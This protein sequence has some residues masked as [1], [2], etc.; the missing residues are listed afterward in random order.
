MKVCG[1]RSS[2]KPTS[3]ENLFRTRPTVETVKALNHRQTD[4]QTDRQIASQT[5]RHYG[6]VVRPDH[7]QTDG[8]TGWIAYR[9]IGRLMAYT[10]THRLTETDYRKIER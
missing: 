9:Q 4:R 7:I 8:Q 5:D 1:R 2:R 3:L 6:Q 10:H